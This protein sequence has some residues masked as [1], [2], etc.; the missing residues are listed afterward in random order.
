MFFEYPAIFRLL[1]QL[2]LWSWIVFGPGLSL[3]CVFLKG[4]RVSLPTVLALSIGYGLMAVPMAGYLY[5]IAAYQPLTMLALLIPATLFNL[6]GLGLWRRKRLPVLADGPGPNAWNW[7][8]L[9]LVL[10]IAFLTYQGK[11]PF[12]AL[13]HW[14]MLGSTDCFMEGTFKYLGYSE[15][16]S[17]VSPIPRHW[18]NIVRGNVALSSTH[19]LIF[20]AAGFRILRVAIAVLL[21]LMGWLLGEHILGGRRGALIGIALFGLNPYVVMIQDMDRNVMALAYAAFLFYLTDRLRAGPVVTG[22]TVGFTAGLGLNLLPLV[23]LAPLSLHFWLLGRNRLRNLSLLYACALPVAALWLMYIG[24]GGSDPGE[25]E[26]FTYHFL[27]MEFQTHYLLAFPFADE[28]VR[29]LE[30][31]FPPVLHFPMDVCRTLGLVVVALS[32]LGL[33]RTWT[34]SKS[35]TIMLLFWGVP[36][37]VVLSMMAILVFDDQLRLVITGLFPVL[38]FALAGIEA[39]SAFKDRAAV[40]GSV[41]LALQLTCLGIT[42]IEFPVDER[43]SDPRHYEYWQKEDARHELKK[44]ALSGIRRIGYCLILPIPNYSPWV[45]SNTTLDYSPLD[46]KMPQALGDSR[47]RW[48]DL[49]DP[50]LRKGL[51]TD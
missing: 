38:L 7:F 33:W 3:T 17:A 25:I 8:G 29:G 14:K 48:R 4:K 30:Q 10:V 50:D 11:Y 49:A 44:G 43:I 42:Q 27:G 5:V 20:G 35:R 39:L 26:P 21:G 9:G 28:L 1:L 15:A 12:V 6:V 37:Y 24:T 47:S 2:A 40:L 23:Y 34:R 32:A 45:F 31:P 13:E 22:L 16:G 46:R 18:D 36:T 51:H 41:Y 19:V